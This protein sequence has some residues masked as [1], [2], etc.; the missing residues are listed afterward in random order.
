MTMAPPRKAVDTNLDTIWREAIDKYN[1][2]E[3]I[4]YKFDLS[5]Q[6][7]QTAEGLLA[8]FNKYRHDNKALDKARTALGKATDMAITVVGAV[9]SLAGAA[10]PPAP[11][12]G[13]AL[14]FVFGAC[15]KTSEKFDQ[16]T[17][18][19]DA[20]L[21]FFERLSLLNSK[22]PSEPA[23]IAQLMRLLGTLFK[24]CGLAQRC[25]KKARVVT[26]VKSII[27]KDNGMAE[28]Y[29]FNR[30]MG[31]LESSTIMATLGISV[32]VSRGMVDAQG[33]LSEQHSML[34]TVLAMITSEKRHRSGVDDGKGNGVGSSQ[35]SHQGYSK[36]KSPER[37]G[38]TVR[39]LGRR[40][41]TA[42]EDVATRISTG[43]ETLLRQGL[44]KIERAYNPGTFAWAFLEEK[45]QTLT[46]SGGVGTGKSVMLFRLFGVLTNQFRHAE[47]T[48]T[49]YFT[50]SDGC[51]NLLSLWDM[52][53]YCALQFAEKNKGYQ[54]QL[55]HFV[56]HHKECIGAKAM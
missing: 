21:I 42:L 52:V 24:M 37:S 26:F 38:A 19:Y 12:I 45:A 46:I 44:T 36:D 16:I 56:E 7:Q 17:A 22:M 32:Q 2:I 25:M 18:F 13:Q 43:A 10:F 20:I 27:Q 51:G 48:Y 15:K 55:I 35:E 29:E 34:S 8:D 14:I 39:D 9:G 30:Q 28:A 33:Q 5:K 54:K 23:Y 1:A 47:N 50:F 49:A 40:R 4:E 53:S 11:T 41:F 3:D 31:H 6:P